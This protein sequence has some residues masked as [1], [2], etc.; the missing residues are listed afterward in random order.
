MAETFTP[1]YTGASDF[2]LGSGAFS[3]P[4][5][6]SGAGAYGQVPGP[7]QPA[8]T[9]PQVV[10]QAIQ[11]GQSVY[12]QLPNYNADLSQIGSNIT[13]ETAG[14]I[15]ADVAAQLAQQGAERGTA[16]GSPGSPNANAALMRSLG[17]TSLN[18]T[19]QGQQNFQNILPSLPG[20]NIA[21]NPGFYLTPGQQYEAG[22][23]NSVFA[24]A[25]DPG[26]AAAANLAAA[27]GGFRAGAGSVG[28]GLPAPTTT[29]ASTGSPDDF[30]NSPVYSGPGGYS[31]VGGQQVDDSV[32]ALQQK[33][34]SLLP[35]TQANGGQSG[36]DIS[37]DSGMALLPTY[38]AGG[39]SY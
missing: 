7:T 18:L 19:Q 20:A 4:W 17:L 14:Q 31:V 3:V 5:N 38:G 30:P 22:L 35:P 33:Y 23:Q 28:H 8:S 39:D 13:S 1:A 34:A 12:N 6:R 11:A 15:P 29:P 10:P 37:D 21:S 32:A 9:A 2:G 27:Q 16:I 26:A 25:P 24:A 36:P